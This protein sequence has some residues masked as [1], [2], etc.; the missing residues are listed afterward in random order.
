MSQIKKFQEGG[1]A[2]DLEAKKRRLQKKLEEE[3]AKGEI[4]R[5]DEDAVRSSLNSFLE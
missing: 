2:P 1:K 4:G 5:K 3:L